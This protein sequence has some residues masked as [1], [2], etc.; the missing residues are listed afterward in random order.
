MK[1]L[2]L[3]LTAA[4]SAF[5]LAGRAVAMGESKG[6]L[7]FTRSVKVEPI[8]TRLFPGELKSLWP[9]TRPTL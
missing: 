7:P 6:Q 1:A 8:Q 4:L 3:I 5:A 2:F 9:F